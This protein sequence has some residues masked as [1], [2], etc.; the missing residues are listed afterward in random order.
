MTLYQDIGSAVWVE[1][2]AIALSMDHPGDITTFFNAVLVSVFIQSKK[3]SKYLYNDFLDILII[4]IYV[5]FCLLCVLI[6]QDLI[7]NAVM[8]LAGLRYLSMNLFLDHGLLYSLLK[9]YS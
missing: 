5:H 9:L 2:Q 4:F 3:K 8:T 6:L 1:Q 7:K